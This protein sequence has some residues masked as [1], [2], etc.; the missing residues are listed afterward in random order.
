[1]NELNQPTYVEDALGDIILI[2][3][4][5]SIIC[6]RVQ[7]LIGYNMVLKQCLEVLR[8]ITAK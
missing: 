6:I 4:I 1:M 3:R 2:N 7:C 5:G 8:A